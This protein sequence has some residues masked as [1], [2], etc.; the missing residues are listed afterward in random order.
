M[1]V[2]I[3]KVVLRDSGLQKDDLQLILISLSSPHKSSLQ[4]M[5]L[6][7]EQQVPAEISPE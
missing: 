6:R 5:L 4:K 7:K 3:L 1:T 2:K